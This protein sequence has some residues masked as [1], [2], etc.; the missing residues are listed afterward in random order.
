MLSIVSWK[1][2]KKGCSDL[3]E[4]REPQLLILE[5][6]VADCSKGTETSLRLAGAGCTRSEEAGL[7]GLD[8]S[9]E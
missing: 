8:L 7:V 3:L 5:C 4:E 9:A 2:L 6:L 1:R